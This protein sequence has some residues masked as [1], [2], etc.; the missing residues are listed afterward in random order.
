MHLSLKRKIDALFIAV[1]IIFIGLF[2][3]ALQSTRFTRESSLLVTQTQEFLYNLEKVESSVS[4][5][6]TAHRGFII[7][8]NDSFLAPLEEASTEVYRSLSTLDTLAANNVP[9]KKNFPF[10]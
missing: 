1:I 7:S 2:Y 9:N 5:I 10:S 6:E 8:G 4:E 3:V